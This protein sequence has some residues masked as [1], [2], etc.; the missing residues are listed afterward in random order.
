MDKYNDD[1][2]VITY[3]EDGIRQITITG[4]DLRRFRPGEFLNDTVI[5]FGLEWAHRQ[6]PFKDEDE[7]GLLV[8]EDI[9]IFNSFFFEK[10]MECDKGGRMSENYTRVRRW[11]AKVDIFR[12]KYL[13]IPINE[14]LHWYLAIISNPGHILTTRPKASESTN[15]KTP[16]RQSPRKLV[17]AADAQDILISASTSSASSPLPDPMEIQST[18]EQEGGRVGPA[19]SL[20]CLVQIPDSQTG[21]STTP[22]VGG[23]GSDFDRILDSPSTPVRRKEREP[24][25]DMKVGD[26]VVILSPEKPVPPTTEERAETTAF[27]KCNIVILDSLGTRH[28]RSFGILRRW[29]EAEAGDKKSLHVEL[30]TDIVPGTHANV[31]GQPNASDCGVYL[32]H[33]LETFLKNDRLLLRKIWMDTYQSK[34][35]A[36]LSSSMT[37]DER[38]WLGDQVIEKRDFFTQIIRSLLSTTEVKT[39][40]SQEAPKKES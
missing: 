23:T 16:V 29:L 25:K 34:K 13:V 5:A 35:L 6:M 20:E 4:S 27:G 2:V 24:V 32:L 17:K 22:V 12:K 7:Q 38:L 30:S 28:N 33:Y 8:N 31:P 3:P 40:Q 39:G 1:E 19:T 26:T 21:T 11:T 10:L 14:N 37:A 9:H 18:F 36:S 15:S